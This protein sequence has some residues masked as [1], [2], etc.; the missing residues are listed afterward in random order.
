MS[1]ETEELSLQ[2]EIAA[3]FKDSSAKEEDPSNEEVIDKLEK[4][5]DDKGKFSKKEEEED[6]D[7]PQKIEEEEQQEEE[8]ESEKAPVTLSNE[9]APAGWSPVVREK[10]GTIDPE[11]R[12]EIIRREEASANGV[13]KLQE[14]HAPVRGFVD[15]LAPFINEAIQGGV[16]P[17]QYIGNVMA[18][19]RNLRS[20]NMEQK[21][22]ALVEIADQYG[23]PLR[24]IINQSVGKEI[25]SKAPAQ[26]QTQLPPQV[27]R[28]LEES[29]RFREQQQQQSLQRE[30]EAFSADKEFFSDVSSIMADFMDS[31]RAKTL[32]EAYEQACWVH[33]DVRKVMLEREKGDKKKE[34]LK[35]RQSDAS[36]AKVK[37]SGAADI[38][39]DDS[40]DD[41]IE[42]EVRRAVKEASGRV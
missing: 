20:P 1:E 22:N 39:V 16:N 15:S 8:Q 5:R 30:I 38:S 10:W 33:P 19:E 42:A 28:E 21:F 18:A 2:E 24:D 13:R 32:A 34:D 7:K 40:D 23:I 3:A 17:A 14:E 4:P 29:R 26:N 41:S 37:S 6:P 35:K 12:A 11:V 25:L 9:K 36:A 27:Q 31:G